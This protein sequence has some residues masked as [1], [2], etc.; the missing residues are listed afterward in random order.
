MAIAHT[1]ELKK[2]QKNLLEIKIK[3]VW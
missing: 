2:M 1:C 3:Y